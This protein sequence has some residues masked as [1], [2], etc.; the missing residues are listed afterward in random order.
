MHKNES[1]WQSFL[2]ALR[3]SAAEQ[4]R[5]QSLVMTALLIAMNIALSSFRLQLTPQTR[6]SF[7]FLISALTGMLFGPV[8]AFNAG[9]IGDILTFFIA[10]GGPYFPGFTLT[11]ALEG[12][13]YG[14]F[15]YRRPV[16]LGRIAAA[17]ISVSLLLN[18]LL[19]TFWLVM[20]YGKSYELLLPARLMKSLLLLPLEILLLVAVGRAAQKI[21]RHTAVT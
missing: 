12:F 9:A 8:V 1:W 6:I 19:N 20:L 14:T 11:A 2:S 16:S 18:V 3:Q 17:R 21:V 10:P 13:L 4:K 15:L 5:L 7:G